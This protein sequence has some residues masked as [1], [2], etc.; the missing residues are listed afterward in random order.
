MDNNLNK[1]DKLSNEVRNRIMPVNKAYSI[2]QLIN[3][4]RDY[5]KKTNR[6][7]T[8]EYVMLNNVNDND[9]ANASDI[10]GFDWVGYGDN[11]DYKKLN[12][13]N[14]GLHNISIQ[15]DGDPVLA[16]LYKAVK[17]ANGNVIYYSWL[18]N[19]YITQNSDKTNYTV[20]KDCLLDE[21]GDYYIS[22]QAYGSDTEY[23]ITS[24]RT[25]YVGQIS[26]T[27]YGITEDEFKAG[28]NYAFTA[29]V[30]GGSY[31]F[32]VSDENGE[33]A[34]GYVWLNIYGYLNN[35]GKYLVSSNLFDMNYYDSQSTAYHILL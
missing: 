26:S 2:N 18:Q 8:I 5:I 14:S 17:D 35:G 3:S 7:V 1:N 4:L 31:K 13:T 30:I 32:T 12:V 24:E 27:G 22:V 16:T 25:V 34:N 11:I 19:A 23:K 29:P 28:K 33:N 15:V 10:T 6:R 9:F 20:F 21:D